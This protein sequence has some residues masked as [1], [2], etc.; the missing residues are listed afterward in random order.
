MVIDAPKDGR[1]GTNPLD[2]ARGE[3]KRERVEEK[4]VAGDSTSTILLRRR[5]RWQRRR[6]RGTCRIKGRKAGIVLVVAEKA[7][8]LFLLCKTTFF[9]QMKTRAISR[10]I[11]F[12]LA[13]CRLIFDLLL[14]VR[15]QGK[16]CR[17]L[18]GQMRAFSP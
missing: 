2:N 16:S 6:R 7:N 8:H 18:L 3:S 12:C 14:L 4:G 13:L 9:L 10:G 15:V 11:S 5:R 1:D 17:R